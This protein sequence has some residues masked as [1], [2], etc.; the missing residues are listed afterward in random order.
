[1]IMQSQT[2]IQETDSVEKET[3]I[4]LDFT[5]KRYEISNMGRVR[6]FARK[7]QG[8]I[9]KGRDIGG[10]YL[11][12]DCKVN[13]T[14]KSY[15]VHRLVA[16]YFLDKPDKK[17][18]IVIHKDGDKSNNQV[19]NLEWCSLKDR[20]KTKR[21]YI[22]DYSESFVQGCKKSQ[23]TY[24]KPEDG[25]E[26]FQFGDK[27]HRISDNGSCLFIRVNMGGKWKSLAIAEI[28][29]ERHGMEKPSNQYKL[30]YKDW[31]YKNLE[32]SNLFWETQAEK[33]RRLL[34]A[35]PLQMARIRKMGLSHKKGIPVKKQ[36]LI[37]KYLL[38]G[39]SIAKISR[40]L[41]IGYTRLYNYINKTPELAQAVNR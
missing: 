12:I 32:P 7:S 9:I 13:G 4:S 16:K 27:Y 21:K 35:R 22:P 26:Y 28:I 20:F 6:S 38:E 40:L 1:M 10:G 39:K 25:H 23:K 37:K 19:A 41:D 3:W 34:E 15:Y 30:G 17:S 24:T 14:K 8:E 11:S 2:K 29:L 5:D 18:N 33:S 31:D 36:E